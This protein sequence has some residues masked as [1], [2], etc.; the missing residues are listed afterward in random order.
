MSS[1]LPIACTLSADE[2]PARLAELSA[3]GRQLSSAEVEG[4]R[5][6]LRFTGGPDTAERLAAVVAAESQC[7]AFLTFELADDGPNVTLTVKAPA[8]TEPLLHD[9]VGTFRGEP[10]TAL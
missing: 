1:R 5:A 8:G 2:R 3:V 6:V 9:F 7:C 4:S 10:P